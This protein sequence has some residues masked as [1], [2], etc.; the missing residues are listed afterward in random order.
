MNFTKLNP[1]PAAKKAVQA[2][3]QGVVFVT[4]HVDAACM[5]TKDAITTKH[6][7]HRE[8][9]A[10]RMEARATKRAEKK[11]AKAEAAEA[12]EAVA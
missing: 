1:I 4:D 11:A 5:R 6:T 10:V 7:A 3:G 12:A 9:M 8:A 2:T